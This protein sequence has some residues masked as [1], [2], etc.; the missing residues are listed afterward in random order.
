M[1][2]Y[3]C[4]CCCQSCFATVLRVAFAKICVIRFI[5]LNENQESNHHP[6][7]R[8]NPTEMAPV[9]SISGNILPP[10]GIHWMQQ[11]KLRLWRMGTAH[12]G[13]RKFTQSY[14]RGAF[15]WV[16]SWKWWRFH[17]RKL[18]GWWFIKKIRMHRRLLRMNVVVVVRVI[19]IGGIFNGLM[20]GWKGMKQWWKST[21]EST[22]FKI[23]VI[24]WGLKRWGQIIHHCWSFCEKDCSWRCKIPIVDRIK[25]INQSYSFVW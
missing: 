17:R 16:A 1:E 23:C 20:Y 9:Q 12:R 11:Q 13:L 8:R 24:L 5:S 7:K 2:Q 21:F 4:H 6:K 3:Y 10:P 14:S 19:R 18:F 25:F 22:A 15:V